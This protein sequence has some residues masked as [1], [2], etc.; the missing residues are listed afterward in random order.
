MQQKNPC[1]DQLFCAFLKSVLDISAADES[2]VFIDFQ[3]SHGTPKHDILMILV[4]YVE[5]TSTITLQVVSSQ[6]LLILYF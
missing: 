1:V 4:G 2:S 3:V 6:S 5:D